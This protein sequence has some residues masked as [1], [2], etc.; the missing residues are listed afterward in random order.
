MKL[1]VFIN[2]DGNCRE[3]VEFYAKVFKQEVPKFMTFGDVPASEGYVASEEDKDRIMY[4]TLNIMG[5]NA[6][7]SDVP[8]GESLIIGNNIAF[9]ISMEEKDE[10]KRIF[11]ELQEGGRVIMDLQET[12]W[13]QCYGYLADRFGIMW[14]VNH[15][16][17]R[18]FMW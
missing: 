1:D 4:T 16:D 5:C 3:A 13:S 11:T 14:Q 2:F 7:F 15:D 6:M 9:T 12:F 10:V 18:E 17:G 8:V